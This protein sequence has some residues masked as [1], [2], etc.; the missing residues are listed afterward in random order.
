MEGGGD[1]ANWRLHL[2]SSV[3]RVKDCAGDIDCHHHHVRVVT[4][5][6]AAVVCAVVGMQMFV[7]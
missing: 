5:A 2:L 7:L 3:D 4:A 6:A 1:A